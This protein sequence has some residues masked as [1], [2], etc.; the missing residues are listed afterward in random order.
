MGVGLERLRVLNGGV[1]LLPF[2]GQVMP[3][4]MRNGNLETDSV[5]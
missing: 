2:Q 1:R 3:L 5:N 4:I